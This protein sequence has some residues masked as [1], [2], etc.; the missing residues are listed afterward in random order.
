[1]YLFVHQRAPPAYRRR[2]RAVKNADMLE[3]DESDQHALAAQAAE[4]RRRAL[5]GERQARGIAHLLEVKV[6]Q[7]RGSAPAVDHDLDTRPLA[8]WQPPARRWWKRWQRR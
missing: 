1:M 8:P 7:L 4:W 2:A 5:R 3:V 6:R